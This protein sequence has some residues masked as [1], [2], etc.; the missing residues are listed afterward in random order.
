MKYLFVILKVDEVRTADDAA[1]RVKLMLFYE[2]KDIDTMVNIIKNL[3]E[4]C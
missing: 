1:I 4:H 2:L 3:R